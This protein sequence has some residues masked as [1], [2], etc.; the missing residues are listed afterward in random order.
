MDRDVIEAIV[1]DVY[2]TELQKEVDPE[3]IKTKTDRYMKQIEQGTLTTIKEGGKEVVRKTTV[4]FSQA[5]VQAE[6]GKEIPVENT[7]DYNR[8]QSL[9]FLTF[10]SGMDG[11]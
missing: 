3:I 1:K 6:L 2:F 5:Q 11:K 10:L 4:P 9:N 7:V 8:A